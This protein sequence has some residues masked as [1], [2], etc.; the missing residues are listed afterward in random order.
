MTDRTRR[1]P[2]GFGVKRAS[3]GGGKR[4]GAGWEQRLKAD[5]QN[6]ALPNALMV[7]ERPPYLVSIH[8]ARSV[9]RRYSLWQRQ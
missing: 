4:S 2:S 1:A 6:A 5:K 3:L 9:A 7:Q 8:A